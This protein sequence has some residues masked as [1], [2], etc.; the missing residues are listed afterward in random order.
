MPHQRRI[1]SQSSQS[2]QLSPLLTA[3]ASS[4][5]TPLLSPATRPATVSLGEIQIHSPNPTS[6]SDTDMASVTTTHQQHFVF[7]TPKSKGKRP[8]SQTPTTQRQPKRLQYQYNPTSGATKPATTVTHIGELN[9]DTGNLILLPTIRE[10]SQTINPTTPLPR[11]YPNNYKDWNQRPFFTPHS[12][13]FFLPRR[14]STT[15]QTLEYT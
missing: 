6:E 8:A 9:P 13:H 5:S 4:P 12:L 10:F 3:S 11:Y 7:P 2:S 15:C 1:A 14:K